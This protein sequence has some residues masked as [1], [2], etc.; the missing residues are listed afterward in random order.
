MY[1]DGA[2]TRIK[3][4]RTHECAVKSETESCSVMSNS[5][6]SHGL[7]SSWNSPGQN[8]GVGSL[9]L[10]QW[11]LPTQESNQGLLHCRWILFQLSYQGSPGTTGST[12]IYHFGGSRKAEINSEELKQYNLVQT[13]QNTKQIYL[14]N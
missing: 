8:T 7:Y 5:L 14:K 1:R 6:Q 12:I 11:I 9:S 13:K 10:F 4:L 3:F 2:K